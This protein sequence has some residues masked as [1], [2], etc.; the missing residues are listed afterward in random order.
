MPF[1][2]SKLK[3]G[4]IL[5]LHTYKGFLPKSIQKFVGTINHTGSVVIE[6]GKIVIWEMLKNGDFPTP[7]ED[8]IK[9]IKEGKYAIIFYEIDYDEAIPTEYTQKRWLEY[10]HENKGTIPYDKVNLVVNQP[11]KI[12]TGIW[13]GKRG[14]KAKHEQICHEHSFS[15]LNH[16]FELNKNTYKANIIDIKKYTWQVCNMID[17]TNIDEFLN[18]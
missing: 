6:D 16:A 1:G 2:I 5:G 13:T 8:Y 9:G 11:I 18:N 7:F 12:L 17:S 4:M 15:H 3:N 10:Y 14:E